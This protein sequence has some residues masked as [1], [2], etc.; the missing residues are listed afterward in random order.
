MLRQLKHPSKLSSSKTVS[1]I[2][3]YKGSVRLDKGGDDTNPSVFSPE[4]LSLIS[5]NFELY[6]KENTGRDIVVSLQFELDTEEDYD[7]KPFDLELWQVLTEE[8]YNDARNNYAFHESIAETGG[9]AIKTYLKNLNIV[10]E[11]EKLRKKLRD[12]S[13][14]SLAKQKKYIKRLKV[15]NAFWTQESIQRQMK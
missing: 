2:I 11:A 9:S 15:L 1:L 13:S 12:L 14:L 10:E 8:E 6:I 3:T 7:E 5:E 4:D